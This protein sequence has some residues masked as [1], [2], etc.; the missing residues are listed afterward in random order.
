MINLSQTYT[1]QDNVV[2][3]IDKTSDFKIENNEMVQHL[4]EEFKNSEAKFDFVKLGKQTIAFIDANQALEPLRVNGF[5]VRQQLCK[6]S[7]KS[8]HLRPKI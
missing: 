5:N 8:G 7:A 6:S 4:A 1:L 3:L 2:F